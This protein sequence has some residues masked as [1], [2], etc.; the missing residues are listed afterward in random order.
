MEKILNTPGFQHL[1]ENIFSNLSSTDLKKCQLINQSS[2]QLLENP[3]FWIQHTNVRITLFDPKY[4]SLNTKIKKQYF[5]ITLTDIKNLIKKWR[6]KFGEFPPKLQDYA[7][8]AKT[9][10]EYG[11]EKFE[12]IDNDLDIIPSNFREFPSK[13]QDY[14]YAAKT[15]IDLIRKNYSEYYWPSSSEDGHHHE[16]LIIDDDLELIPFLLD[17]RTQE[18]MI[19]IRCLIMDD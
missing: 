5:E 3:M 9:I 15:S 11:F 14:T 17:A 4:S 18:N 12:I 6:R 7:Y 1:A 10:D 8:A 16:W 2:S 19:E 13:L